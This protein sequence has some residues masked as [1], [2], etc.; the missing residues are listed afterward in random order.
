[1]KI[2]VFIIC[3]LSV[4]SVIY[5][6][7]E[8]TAFNLDGTS[9]PDAEAT[10][11]ST[12]VNSNATFDNAFVQAMNNWNGLS[13]F[14]FK[15]VSGSAD[16]CNDPNVY[17]PPYLNGWGFF[18]DN[19]GVSFGDTTLAVTHSWSGGNT[20]GQAGIAFNAYKYWNVHSGSSD[21]YWDFRRVATHELGHALGLDHDNTYSALMNELYSET[22][23]TPQADDINGLRAIYGGTGTVSPSLSVSPTSLSIEVVET[24]T[25]TISGGTAPYTIASS[26]TTVATVDVATLS[27]GGDIVVTGT[28]VGSAIITVTDSAATPQS[29]TVSVTVFTAT[30]IGA[31]PGA[32]SATVTAVESFQLLINITHDDE[33]AFA[34]IAQ[35]WLFFT[36]SVGD[37]PVDIG[38]WLYP[39]SGEIVNLDG[40]ATAEDIAGATFSFDHDAGDTHTIL[41]ANLADLLGLVAG[42]YLI[43]GYAYSTTEITPDTIDTVVVENSVT[44]NIQ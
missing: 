33:V 12:G 35:E 7:S 43:Y 20:I 15:N 30:E 8:A 26:N 3:V 27:A 42:N 29:V 25:I 44:I 4:F 10:M 23:E 1:M 19:C 41:T 16:P 36:A 11:Y 37:P 6:H 40:L 28:A 24:E 21:Y 17:G 14:V 34:D 39:T 13:N 5:S 31:S 2:R 32:V 18:Y 22:I 9:W 38:Y